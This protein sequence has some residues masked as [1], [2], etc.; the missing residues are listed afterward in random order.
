MGAASGDDGA[1]GPA[2]N[3]FWAFSWA[4]YH[5]TGVAEACLGL[6]ER[7][8][9]DVN[10]LLFCTWAGRQGHTLTPAQIESLRAQTVSWQD[11]VIVP[12][13]GVRSWLKR[14]G[15]GADAAA[16]REAVKAAEFDAERVEQ[17]KLY[18]TLPLSEGAPEVGAMVANVLRYFRSLGRTPGPEDTA[19]LV[20]VL[21]AGLPRSMRALD[22][23]RRV[24]DGG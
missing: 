21:L 11:A 8:D 2:E 24:E 3:P 14:H 16:L 1:A 18:R 15:D 5:R 23:M 6:Q 13:R 10:V 22:L 12:L 17:D 9:L 20:T 19:D 4:V 7:A